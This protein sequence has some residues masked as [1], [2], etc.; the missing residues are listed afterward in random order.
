MSEI[1]H[2]MS[3]IKQALWEL[4]Y[5]LEHHPDLFKNINYAQLIDF[6]QTIKLGAGKKLDAPDL[7]PLDIK[8]AADAFKECLELALVV[9]ESEIATILLEQSKNI[10]QILEGYFI[11]EIDAQIISRR[12]SKSWWSLGKP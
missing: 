9:K 3:E 6:S 5:R 2:D 12:N 4:E 8:R 11:P 10:K 1:K 7:T